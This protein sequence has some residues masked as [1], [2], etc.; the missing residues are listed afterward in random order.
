MSDAAATSTRHRKEKHCS[1]VH[2]MGIRFWKN[3]DSKFGGPKKGLGKWALGAEVDKLQV[4]G[5]SF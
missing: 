4:H 3:S 5:R 1:W 2:R